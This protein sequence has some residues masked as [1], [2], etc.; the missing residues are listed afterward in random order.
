MDEDEDEDKDEDKDKDEDEEHEGEADVESVVESVVASVLEEAVCE[1]KDGEAKEEE[2]ANTLETQ[3]DL[4]H[5]EPKDASDETDGHE[6]S[7]RPALYRKAASP[8]TCR[9]Q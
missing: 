1:A 6:A 8:R 9:P 7:V 2:E 5:G 3:E 4:D